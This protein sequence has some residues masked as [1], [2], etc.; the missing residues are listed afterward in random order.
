[1]GR[2]PRIE[3]PGGIYHVIQRGNNREFLFDDNSGKEMLLDLLAD[4][5]EKL[6]FDLFGYVIMG[7]HYH[8]II[9]QTEASLQTIMHRVLSLFGRRYNILNSRSGHVFEYRY[10]AIPVMDDKYLMSLLRYIHRNPVAANI[11]ARV[12]DYA[13]SSDR[14]Y[15][16][17]EQENGLVD[18]N[19]ILD[20]ISRNRPAALKS[21][22]DFMDDKSKDDIAAFEEVDFIG[23]KD[24]LLIDDYVKAERMPLNDLLRAVTRE[25]RLY[26]Q[27]KSG[28]RRR[29]LTPYKKNF[30]HAAY[31]C[32]Y[33]MEEI[34]KCMSISDVAVFYLMHGESTEKADF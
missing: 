3:Y 19:Y 11:C 18:I 34:G 25:D 5:R 17:N 10:K 6:G 7:N 2:K 31:S 14:I 27:I 24:L 22:I 4:Y 13:W 16:Q 20:I 1:M 8:L 26:Q 21:Y 23:E 29:Q 12:S 9:R 32:G 15:R 30:I 33:T 28:S